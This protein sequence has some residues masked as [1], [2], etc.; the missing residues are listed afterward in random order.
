MDVDDELEAEIDVI[1]SGEFADEMSLMQFPL[2]PK[3]NF[4]QNSI[5]ALSVN[6]KSEALKIEKK[7]DTILNKI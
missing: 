3:D 6:R 1:Y 7:I 5:S 4:K 2:I